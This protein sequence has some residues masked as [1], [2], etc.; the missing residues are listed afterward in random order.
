MIEAVRKRVA[1]LPDLP[2][3]LILATG[4]LASFG[5]LLVQDQI[6]PLFV[7]FLQLYLTF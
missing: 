6:H 3:Q 2:L 1:T 7:Y 5:W 4:T